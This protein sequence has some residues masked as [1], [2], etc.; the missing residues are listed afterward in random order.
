MTRVDPLKVNTWT[1]PD[2]ESSQA[3]RGGDMAV[4]GRKGEGGSLRG[5]WVLSHRE[6]HLGNT[7]R[8]WVVCLEMCEG[9]IR[10]F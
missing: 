8:C 9:D 5:V 3:G 4:E 2:T 7:G 10:S 6:S 1:L